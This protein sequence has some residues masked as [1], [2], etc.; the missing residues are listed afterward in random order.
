[1]RAGSGVP[2]TAIE[3]AWTKRTTGPPRRAC[4]RQRSSKPIVASRLTRRPA[5]K[6][7]SAA[8]LTIAAR[9]KTRSI[10]CANRRSR[11]A[12]SAMSPSLRSVAITS[13]PTRSAGRDLGVGEALDPARQLA[14]ARIGRGVRRGGAPELLAQGRERRRRVDAARELGRDADVLEH[15]RELERIVE[16]AAQHALAD[17]RARDPRAAGRLVEDVDHRRRIEPV[18]LADREAFADGDEIDRRDEVVE[19]L[20][21][22]AGAERPEME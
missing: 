17:V 13:W 14:H 19:A 6:S 10:G 5:S 16:A 4:A 1:M 21:R 8:P 2:K 12:G 22:V 20:H 9:W 15:Q 3:L 18:A 11:C 7:A